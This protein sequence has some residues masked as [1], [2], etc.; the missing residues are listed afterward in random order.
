MRQ[1]INRFFLLPLL[2]VLACVGAFA[3]ANSTVTGIVT[4][5]TGAVVAG[6]KIALTDPA[7]G[8]TKVTVSG[9]TGLYDIAGLNP[10]KY[11]MAVTAPGFQTFA[12]SGIVVNI[13]ATFRVDVKLT[14]G[15]EATTVTVVADALAVQS[16][17]NVVSTLINEQQITE[18]A[19]NSRNIVAL[20]SLGL[21]VSGNLP[22][23]NMPTSVG[24]NF[25]IS[26]NGLNQAHNIWLIDGGEAYDRGSGGKSSMMPSQDAL[27]EFQVLAS[28]YPPDYGISTGGTISMSIKRGS[29]AFHGGVVGVRSQRCTA[30]AQLFRCSRCQRSLNFASTSSVAMSAARC[31]FLMSTT[32]ASRRPSSS[33]TKSG[34]RSFRAAPLPVC[35]LFLLPISSPLRQ[36]NHMGAP[37]LCSEQP[38]TSLRASGCGWYTTRCGN[39]GQWPHARKAVPK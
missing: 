4:D 18:L 24:S 15:A 33:T 1:V 10:A 19:T 3:Q 13:S 14:V 31:S 17:S 5:Q 26:F 7:T 35:T 25:A 22:D 32:R 38:D 39:R 29:Q 36:D 16:D 27:G 21:G 8:A 28:N 12:Q 30:G 9:V 2:F 11:N 20:A 37:R 34:A 6:A 23:S